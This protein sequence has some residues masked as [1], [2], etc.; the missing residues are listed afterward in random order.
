MTVEVIKI[1]RLCEEKLREIAW[2]STC[3]ILLCDNFGCRDYHV[4]QGW[5]PCDNP[6]WRLSK[7]QQ[8]G[9]EK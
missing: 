9:G 4:P 5:V 7:C 1:C 2:N 3:N 8:K 6:Y